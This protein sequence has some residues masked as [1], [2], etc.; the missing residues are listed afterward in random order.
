MSHV[1]NPPCEAAIVRAAPC[2]PPCAAIT[3]RWVLAA[4]VTGSSMA[5]I[6]G[7][8]VNVALPA[9]QRE[10]D[11]GVAELQWVVESYML[12]LASLILVG[13]AL[14]DRYGRRRLFAIG[15]VVFAVTSVWC[16]L[17]PD[18]SQLIAARA[19]QGVGGAMLVPG[20]LSMIS[21]SFGEEQRGRAFG[22]WSAATA[23][24]MAFGPVL[25]GWLVDAVS[26]RWI[27]F[28]NVPPA[29]A[30]VWI[31]YARVPESRDEAAPAGL[32]WPGALLCTLGLGLVIYGLIEA[33]IVG[34]ASPQVWGTLVAGAAALAGFVAVQQRSASPMMPLDLFRSRSFSGANLVTLLLYAAFSGALFFLPFNLVQVH[35]YSTTAAG[36]AMLPL[37]LIVS[38]LSRWSGDL[39]SRQGGRLPLMIG[40]AIAAAGFALFTLPGTD[41]SYWTTFFPAITV[42]G[43]GMAVSVAPL[44]TVVMGAVETRRAGIASAINNAVSRI[45]GLLAIAVMGIVVTTSFN[46]GLDERLSAIPMPPEARSEVD[47][48]R[49]NLAGAEPPASLDSALRADLIRAIDEAFVDGFRL[50]MITAAALALLGAGVAAVS[51]APNR[52]D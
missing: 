5:F 22:I 29:I 12:L 26:W 1:C 11:A 18:S 52:A 6:D 45:A 31:L 38:T 50:A 3:G 4:S 9:L 41:G 46:A 36:A 19:A 27:F 51:I 15:T 37:I 7:T 13:G 17:A 30:V 44:T 20:S 40:P 47:A 39:V 21:A 23:L 48:Q 2:P 43:L 42:L 24:A 25:G 14:G 10:L 28:I 35:G 32:D 49:I 8:V 34:F 16:G 33:G